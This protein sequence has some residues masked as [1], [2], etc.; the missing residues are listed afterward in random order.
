[1]DTLPTV[2]ACVAYRLDGK[3]I[4]RFPSRI[5]D[6]ARCEP[7]YEEFPGWQTPLNEFR[8]FADLP[9]K[10][11]R[12]LRRLAEL[13]GAPIVLVGVGQERR[14]TIEVKSVW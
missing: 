12:Y 13:I 9:L 10:A 11:R 3:T 1:M 5:T 14:Q 2:K 6:V 8:R 7:V 4:D